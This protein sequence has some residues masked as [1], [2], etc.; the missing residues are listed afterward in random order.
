MSKLINKVDDRIEYIN[1]MTAEEI[2]EA[3]NF[4]IHLQQQ[5]TAFEHALELQYKKNSIEYRYKIGEFLNEQITSNN[6][7]S[8]ERIYIWNEI[9]YLTDSNIETAEDRGKGREFYEYCYR[10]FGFGKEIAQSLTWSQWVD[11]LDRSA[12]LKD[13]RFIKWYVSKG[14]ISTENLRLLLLILNVYLEKRDMSVFND[15]E[16]FNKYDYLYE[17]VL[18]WNLLFNKYFDGK[19]EKLTRAREKNF[20]KYKKKFINE[21]ILK[22]KFKAKEEL[23]NICEEVFRKHFVDI[24]NSLNFKK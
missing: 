14:K 24:D 22:S 4:L 1:S 17:I 23:A 21:T 5:V 19:K 15:T 13:E 8:K 9:K 11:I 10:I 12:A 2:E 20:T 6:I 3:K 16:A 18:Q 7:S